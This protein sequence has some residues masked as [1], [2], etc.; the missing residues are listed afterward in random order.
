[1][2][3]VI[4]MKKS[5]RVVGMSA[6][7]LFQGCGKSEKE[8]KNEIKGSIVKNSPIFKDI[9]LNIS[10]F[11][12]SIPAMHKIE[13]FY[14]VYLNGVFFEKYSKRNEHF[15]IHPCKYMLKY[16][17]YNPKFL[18]PDAPKKIKLIFTAGCTGTPD[19]W[20][21]LSKY[22]YRESQTWSSIND[23]QFIQGKK[24]NISVQVFG[25]KNLNGYRSSCSA[26]FL[27][28]KSY[29][30]DINNNLLFIKIDAKISK[31]TEDEKKK[32]ESNNDG[33]F[34]PWT[35]SHSLKEEEL[36]GKQ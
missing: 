9:G 30:H 24:K 25:N 26:H 35:I 31:I 18:V 6:I 27:D 19:A 17:F 2:K 1:M 34:V 29:E 3:R 36:N 12:I 21:D 32:L 14:I 11:E 22:D 7:L 33:S 20:I 5:L 10:S 8:N 4:K 28:I 13:V 16:G 23:F 15:T